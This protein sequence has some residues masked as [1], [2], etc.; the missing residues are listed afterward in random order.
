LLSIKSEQRTH[1]SWI[2]SLPRKPLLDLKGLALEFIMRNVP[3]SEHVMTASTWPVK[4]T[5]MT[6]PVSVFQ[7]RAVVFIKFETTTWLS[8]ER[9]V[10]ETRFVPPS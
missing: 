10:E 9:L 4:G 6:W 3:S 1:P 2:E 8:G 7:T 5:A